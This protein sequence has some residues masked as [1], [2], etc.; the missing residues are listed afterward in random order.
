M[1]SN[2]KIGDFEPH[3]QISKKAEFKKE[4]LLEKI[5]LNGINNPVKSKKIEAYFNLKGSEIRQLIKLLRREGHPIASCA[6]GYFYALTV[7]ELMPTIN[8]MRLR[9]DSISN[10]VRSLMNNKIFTIN[11]EMLKFNID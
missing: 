2:M 7:D 9:R 6:K 8:H 10:T 3:I 11:Q 4:E 1:M 5:K